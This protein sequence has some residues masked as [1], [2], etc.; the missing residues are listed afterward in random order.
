MPHTIIFGN[1]PL[2]QVMAEAGLPES[3][4]SSAINR[5]TFKPTLGA[6]GEMLAFVDAQKLGADL[7]KNKKCYAHLQRKGAPREPGP[8][9]RDTEVAKYGTWEC[10]IP[11]MGFDQTQPDL[12][13][14]LLGDTRCQSDFWWYH[15]KGDVIPVMVANQSWGKR[16]LERFLA[17]YALE[18][19]FDL[20][21]SAFLEKHRFRLEIWLDKLP[22]RTI[23]GGYIKNAPYCGWS[24]RDGM[25][26]YSHNLLKMWDSPHAAI[27]AAAWG[28]DQREKEFQSFRL[29]RQH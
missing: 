29:S 6:E 23:L 21:Q 17:K 1:A 7:M 22:E 28:A 19:Q 25:R 15:T 12:P 24:S 14:F 5:C 16:T 13:D 18:P 26:R 11:L 3:L 20:A 2:S 27:I 4:L 8:C 10:E 9:H